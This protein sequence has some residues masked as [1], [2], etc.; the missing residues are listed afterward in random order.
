MDEYR[1]LDGLLHLRAQTPKCTARQAQEDLR[2]WK[3]EGVMDQMQV[4]ARSRARRHRHPPADRR[5]PL[6]HPQSVRMGSTHFLD[7][8]PRTRS[9]GDELHIL[10]YTLK[11]M[12]QILG[13]GPL[14]KAISARSACRKP[15]NARAAVS[16]FLH[17]LGQ[18]QAFASDPP[19][20]RFAPEADIDA[21]NENGRTLPLMVPRRL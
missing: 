15:F 20:V 17:S 10:A 16:A 12:I 3:H 21:G 2:R 14:I 6:R 13:V 1:H 7:R 8:E 5:A 4:R 19:K 18:K 9:N 11:R